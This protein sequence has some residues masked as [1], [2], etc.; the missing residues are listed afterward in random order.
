[1]RL[2][3]AMRPTFRMGPGGP[4]FMGRGE[5]C[6]NKLDHCLRPGVWFAADDAV[7][8]KLFRGT[9]VFFFEGKWWTWRGEQAEQKHV[10]RT[11]TVDNE[12]EIQLGKP[13]VF[14]VAEGSTDKWLLNEWDMLTSSRWSV[15]IVEAVN[16]DSV[17]IQGWGNASF[18]SLRVIIEEKSQ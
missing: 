17:K 14:L 10:Y 13:I 18:A 8:G 1:M 9:P 3:I 15:G 4:I 6:T 2:P 11:K 5:P 7:A 12:R 16:T